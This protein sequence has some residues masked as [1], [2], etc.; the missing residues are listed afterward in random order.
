MHLSTKLTYN[1]AKPTIKNLQNPDPA[2]QLPTLDRKTNPPSP[3]T[4]D[5]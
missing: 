3:T 2:Q 5:P 1:G 4:P